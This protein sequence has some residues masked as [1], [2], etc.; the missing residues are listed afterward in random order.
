MS[1]AGQKRKIPPIPVSDTTTL[2]NKTGSWK[3]IRP[4]YQDRVAPCNAGCP[5]GIDIEGYLNLLREERTDEAMELL[6]RENPIPAV[7]GRVCDHPCEVVCNRRYFDEAVAIHS[8]ERMLGD[9]ILDAPLPE[10]VPRTHDERIA[11]IGSG[12]AGLACAYHMTRQGYAV[13]VFEA[14]AE[15]GGMLRL[16]IPEY[17]LPRD[18][19][20]RQIARIEA[21]GVEFKC[22][23]VVGRDVF[24]DDLADFAAV[25]VATG[26]HDGRKMGMEGE[27][28]E[29]VRSGLDF[30]KE[31]NGGGRP[32]P[33]CTPSGAYPPDQ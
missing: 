16:G 1:D 7:T 27:D 3:Y 33:R 17:R 22:A 26:A 21:L 2:V 9:R 31:V 13:T 18:V 19:L 24:W 29:G 8:V 15:A 10:P 30:L 11:V 6:I 14:A 28:V 5:V 12:P 25:F 20:D 4:V 23:T 32:D